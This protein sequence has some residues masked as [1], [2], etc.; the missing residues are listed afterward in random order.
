MVT[1]RQKLQGW[2]NGR[3]A[4]SIPSRVWSS[5]VA[6]VVAHPPVVHLLATATLFQLADVRFVVTAAHAVRRASEA[7]KT[8]GVSGGIDGH[9]VSLPG[10]WMCSGDGSGSDPHDVAIFRMPDELASRFSDVSCLRLS[11]VTLEEPDPRGV[12]S[13]F[14][15]PGVWASPSVADG[16]PLTV[17]PLEVTT[18]AYVGERGTMP[19]YDSRLHILLSLG[20]EDLTSPDGTPLLFVDRVNQPVNLPLG[21]KGVSGCSVWYIGNLDTP[22]ETWT[23]RPARLAGV[24]TSAYRFHQAIRATRWIS[25]TTLIN[26]AYPDLRPVLRLNLL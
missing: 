22:I 18:Y 21:I 11:D 9:F 10:Q 17:K 8:L 7:G 3:I 5:T 23:T 19:G 24:Q 20:Q 6:L 1:E 15:Y 14:G 4:P 12:Y 25:V 13:L 16:V 26:E 2:I